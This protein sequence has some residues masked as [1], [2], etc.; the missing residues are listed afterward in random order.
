[1]GQAAGL[2]QGITPPRPRR[3]AR[4]ELAAGFAAGLRR[5]DAQTRSART[6]LT[7]AVRACGTRSAGLGP[8]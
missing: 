4:C 3:P 5:L 6:K 2:L 8:L 1:M 7:A